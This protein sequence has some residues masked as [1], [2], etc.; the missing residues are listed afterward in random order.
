[1]KINSRDEN[2]NIFL[3][4]IHTYSIIKISIVNVLKKVKSKKKKNVLKKVG[5]WL[6]AEAVAPFNLI[7][8]IK[9]FLFMS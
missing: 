5:M 2:A 3:K 1:M 6:G 4:S 9:D 8:F 7:L